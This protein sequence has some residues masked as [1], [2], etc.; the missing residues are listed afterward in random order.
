MKERAAVLADQKVQGDRG[1]LNA[2]PEGVAVRDL[3]LDKDPKFHDLE[4]QRAKLKAS[5][6]NP[7]KIK[8]LE[9]QLNAQAEE[10]ARALKKKDLEGLNQKPEGIP[11]DLLDPHGDAE[12]AAYLPQLREL[13]KDPKANKA[14]I[15]DLQQA[16]NDRVKQLA[17]DKL[18]GDRP[19]YVEDVVDGVPH[20]ILPLDKDPKFHELEVQRAVLRTKDPR[21]NA[22]K[23]KDL[24]TKLHDRVTELAAEQKKKDLECLDQNPEGMP[25]N[26]LN[27]HADSEFAQLVEAHRELM[28]DPKK[29]AEALQDLEVQMNNCVHELAKEK[30]MNDRAY[31]EKDPQGVSLTDL[32]LDKDEKFKAMEA[33]RAKLKALDARRN[34]AKIKKLEDELNDRLHELARHQLEEDLK[35]VNDEPRG[36]PIDFLK[37]NEDSQFV[38]LVKKARALKKDPNRDE[39]E[40]AYVVA[41][42]NERVDD[43]AGEAMKRTF[44][45]TNPE[46]VPL[47]ELPLDF[48]EQFHELEV[49]RAKLK[50]K[51]PI[52]NRQKIRDLEDQMNARVLELAREQIAEDLAPCEANPRGIPLELLRPQEDEEIAKVI[53]QLRALKKDP[54]Q[55]AEK[56]KELENGMKERARALA[57]AK[58]DGDRDYL[59][60][61]P[62][63]VPL[64]FLPLDTD[65]IFAEKEAQRAKLKAQNARRNAKQILTLEG[66]LNARACELA[67]KKKED[68]LA[69][70]PLRYDEMNTAGLKPHEDPEFN[71]LLNKYRVLAKGGEGESAAASALKEDM[72]KR[73]AELAKE[74]KDGDLWFLERSPEG[75]PLAE[76]SLAKDKEFQNMRAERAKLKAEDPRRNAKRITELEIAMNNRAHA[77]ANQTK[78]SDFEDVD[79]NPRGIPLELLKPRDDSQV[80]STLLGLREA[81]RN[82]EAK[83]TNMLAEKLKERVDQLAKAALTGDRHSYLDPE[84]EGVALEH[85]PL[86]KD[87]IF[88]RFEEERAKLKLQD[89]VKNAK[90][91][92]DLEDRLNDRARELAMQVKQNDLKNI[93]QRPRDV[94]LDAIKPHEDKSFNEL[95]KQLRVL[96]KDP[97]R[98][99]NKIRDIEGKMNTMVNKMADN[100]LAGN[101]TYL[102]EA[103]NGVA[104]AVLPLDADPTFHNLEVQ[105]ATL[106]AEDPV[107]NKKQCEDL[108]HQL[109]E[110]AKELAD[111]VKRA[112]L[113]QLDAAPLGVP[114]DLLSPPR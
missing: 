36:V 95:A 80:Q 24:E 17:D 87:D 63:D 27:P 3:P 7:A 113:A 105:R 89:P 12:F 14:A 4:V 56:I 112:D 64:E 99:A 49:E 11:I 96:N 75:I 21:R 39:E 52:R 54:K 90:Q 41:A 13:K 9:E 34:A 84:P 51:D 47:S 6:G 69:M 79:P 72:G 50:L 78:K 85:L 38:E 18:C 74:K 37:P 71:G 98:N 103:P 32:P 111:E 2:N 108:E 42:M 20:D 94:P 86:D 61:K 55:N 25:L 93:N 59:N 101:R 28:K 45:E 83:K 26:I 57:S 58:L 60:P 68:E 46:G 15:N 114:V 35:E 65:P 66:D 53:P 104:L 109:K 48:D 62:N 91:I 92:E 22:D 67:D 106:A 100:M 16:M 107:R 19:K 70:F 77:L 40:L 110:R 97:V 102:D 81:K 76:L 88:S 43:L 5:G 31:L 8:E 82:K 30:L 10:L 1:F 23:I 44:L 73:L 33:E 29:N